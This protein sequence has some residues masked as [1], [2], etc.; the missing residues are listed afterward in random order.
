[1]RPL[2]WLIGS[3]YIEERRGD[4]GQPPQRNS[5]KLQRNNKCRCFLLILIFPESKFCLSA[6]ATAKLAVLWANLEKHVVIDPK[7]EALSRHFWHAAVSRAMLSIRI[8]PRLC[9]NNVFRKFLQ[10][11]FREKLEANYREYTNF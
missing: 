8:P 3:L 1:M 10:C 6:L 9:S 5:F 4:L 2:G 11:G 7:L